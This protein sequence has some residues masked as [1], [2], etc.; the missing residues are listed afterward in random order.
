MKSSDLRIGNYVQGTPFSHPRLGLNS[1]G[2]TEIMAGGI[3]ALAEQEKRFSGET[4]KMEGLIYSYDDKPMYEPIPLT[5]DYLLRLGFEKHNDKGDYWDF[6]GFKLWMSDETNFYHINSELLIN[7]DFVHQLQN[8]Y[9]A[10][11][12]EELKLNI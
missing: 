12:G 10:I 3:V 2:V 5:E 11:C 6:E 1:D 4:P 8:F 9:Y 7:F